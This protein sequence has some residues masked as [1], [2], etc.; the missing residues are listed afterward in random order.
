MGFHVDEYLKYGKVEK[1]WK[2]SANG[3][4]N[5]LVELM[6]IFSLRDGKEA[7]CGTT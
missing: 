2:E 7:T 1:H 3:S 5:S 6:S 4:L